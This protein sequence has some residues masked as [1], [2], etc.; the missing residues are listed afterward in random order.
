MKVARKVSGCYAYPLLRCDWLCQCLLTKTRVTPKPK[1]FLSKRLFA[2]F[3]SLALSVLLLSVAAVVAA[4]W[5]VYE[6]D[7]EQRLSS[8]ATGTAAL[9]SR[10]EEDEARA[11]LESLALADTRVTLVA[12]DGRVVFDNQATAATMSNHANREE[13]AAGC[14]VVLGRCR[15][16]M[17]SALRSCARI[18][19]CLGS[20]GSIRF[21]LQKPDKVLYEPLHSPDESFSGRR[22]NS[23]SSEN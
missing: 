13:I 20:R 3:F 1:R 2:A 5:T 6:G 12:G 11:S 21:S 19:A 7:T 4:S 16:A 22:F 10:V 9:L 18:W 23:D 15:K 8:Q 14:I 17:T